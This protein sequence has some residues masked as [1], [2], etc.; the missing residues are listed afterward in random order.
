MENVRQIQSANLLTDN[1]AHENNYAVQ[2]DKD[3]ISLSIMSNSR[4]FAEGLTT[5]LAPHLQFHV[6]GIYRLDLSWEKDYP[7]PANHIVLIDVNAGQDAALA[8]IQ[9]WRSYQPRPLVIVIESP[10]NTQTILRYIEA[11]ANGY[12]VQGDNA[13]EVKHVIDAACKGLA[14]CSPKVAAELFLRVAS[15][16]RSDDLKTI[17]LP[18]SLTSRELEVLRCIAMGYSNKEIAAELVITIHTVKHHVHSILEKLALNHRH[19]AAQVAIGQG[20]TLNT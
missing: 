17:S 13:E 19:E 20:W 6:T 1:Y 4:L 2:S 11:G 15:H 3:L 5:V 9:Y 14:R 8:C 12:S 10:L 7:N 16:P 18:N